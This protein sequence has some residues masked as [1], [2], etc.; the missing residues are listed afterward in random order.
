MPFSKRKTKLIAKP[1][2]YGKRGNVHYPDDRTRG[3]RPL[4]AVV[5]RVTL[6][7]IR[8]IYSC[9]NPLEPY[10]YKLK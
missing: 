7:T 10:T 5:P 2:M 6:D 4:I 9:N 8:D 1:K 3:G